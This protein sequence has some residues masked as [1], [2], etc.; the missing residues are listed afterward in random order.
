MVLFGQTH[1]H[2]T[3]LKGR[4]LKN[5]NVIAV[6][7]IVAIEISTAIPSSAK[8]TCGLSLKGLT[9]STR[10][11]ECSLVAQRCAVLQL[12]KPFLL[13]TRATKSVVSL[14]KKK[15]KEQLQEF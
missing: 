7:P 11:Q 12:Y 9:K 4:H 3:L 15:K 5:S 2:S 6:P 8:W 14:T 10:L 13:Q 1:C